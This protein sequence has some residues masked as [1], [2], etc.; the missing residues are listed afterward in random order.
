MKPNTKNKLSVCLPFFPGFY[1]SSLSELVDQ[2]IEYKMESTGEGYDTVSERFSA[3]LAMS[4]ITREWVA[5][6]SDETGIAMDF[7][8]VVS[9]KEYNFTTDRAF[10]F[11]PAEE[12]RRIAP[13]KDTP[14]FADVLKHQFT[15]YDGFIPFYSNRVSAEEWQKPVL[16]W[17]H[18]QL[19]VLV[20]AHILRLGLS[21]EELCEDIES[22]SR[23]YEAAQHGWLPASCAAA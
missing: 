23:V 22:K 17:D 18:N 14:E 12:I 7:E 19:M 4:A 2:E 15:G 3:R 8:E 16:E 11:V 5:A 10:A 6:F 9:P 13:A 1:E 20:E 21:R